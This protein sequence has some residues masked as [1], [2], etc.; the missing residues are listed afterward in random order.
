MGGAR[1][2]RRGPYTGL[3]DRDPR[4]ARAVP[5]RPLTPSRRAG[6]RR[7][8]SAP[9]RRVATGTSLCAPAA[10]VLWDRPGMGA[11]PGRRA[12]R[13]RACS[14]SHRGRSSASAAR[15]PTR[16]HPA[17]QL[18]VGR[19]LGPRVM[20]LLQGSTHGSAL[21]YLH[22]SENR[23]LDVLRPGGRA[24]DAHAIALGRAG[25]G[26]EPGRD[27][28]R[29]GHRRDP[30]PHLAPLTTPRAQLRDRVTREPAG[31]TQP[32]TGPGADPGSPGGGVRRVH[33][34]P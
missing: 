32:M 14:R 13:R 22:L 26:G 31:P 11:G 33:P 28:T 21:G 8:R 19:E 27:R 7:S 17:F 12:A 15:L 4:F 29:N 1:E 23:R 5:S 9:G 6:G 30:R 18:A 24:R 2:G 10:A 3:A 34:P 25:G 20:L 16:P